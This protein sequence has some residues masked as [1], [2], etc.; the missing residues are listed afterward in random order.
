[1]KKFIITTV[2]LVVACSVHQQA[3]AQL[4]KKLK[5]KA[6]QVANKV[7][8][9]KVDEAVGVDDANNTSNNGSSPSSPGSTGRNGKPS[10][11]SGEGLKNTTPPDVNQQIADAEKAH[12]AGNYSEA[13][14]SIQ[15]AMMG[16]E[17]QIGQEILKSLP[18][19]VDNL[20][21]DTTQDRVMSTRWGWANLTMQRVYNKD[22]KQLTVVIGNNPLYS[23][24]LD[25]YFNGAYGYGTES[26]GET[27]NMKQIK[28]KGYKAMIKFDQNE[29]YTIL[30]QL[31]QSGM[32]TFQGINFKDEAEITNAANSFDIDGIKNMLGEK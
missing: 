24:A 30:V 14:Y 6:D 26:N 12:A 21:K 29:G 20:P 22:D 8:D 3:S 9:K 23:N 1:M 32:I 18:A 10:N 25:L 4:L 28:V 2:A 15:Q 7:I 19:T 16:V 27:Q 5:A 11:T 13:R 31:G 17:I